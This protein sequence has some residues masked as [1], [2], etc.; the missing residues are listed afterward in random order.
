[1]LAVT[2]PSPAIQILVE[3]GIYVE[4][5][6]GIRRLGLG[7]LFRFGFEKGF[8]GVILLGH[9]GF[10][11]QLF[12]HRVGDHLLIDHFA[13]LQPVQSQHADHL[14]QARCQ[15]LLLCNFEVELGL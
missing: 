14:N 1:M 4:L 3:K 9:L 2:V 10:F 15:N 11:S 8:F 5:I 6:K 13:K 7:N 12:Q